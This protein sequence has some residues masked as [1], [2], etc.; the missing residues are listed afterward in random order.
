MQ[1]DAGKPTD[2]GTVDLELLYGKDG[3]CQVGGLNDSW[4]P[5]GWGT[6]AILE[7]FAD[8]VMQSKPLNH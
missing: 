7:L 2:F 1:D 8:Q 4:Q 6:H 3:W 5:W